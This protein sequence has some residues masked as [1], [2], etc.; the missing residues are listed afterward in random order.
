M[1][2]L[3]PNKSKM[4]KKMWKWK[5]YKKEYKEQIKINRLPSIQPS[6]YPCF[7]SRLPP[8]LKHRLPSRKKKL[9]EVDIIL[10][11]MKKCSIKENISNMCFTDLFFSNYVYK[12]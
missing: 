5:V 2:E 12:K 3:K 11:Q 4:E 10:L 8:S 7:T 1:L 9:N 6:L